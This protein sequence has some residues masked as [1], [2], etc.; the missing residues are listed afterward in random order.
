MPQVKLT[1]TTIDALPTPPKDTVYWDTGYPGF[2][3]KVTPKGRKVFVVFIGQQEPG[4]G[5]ANIPSDPMGESLS[6]RRV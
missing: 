5:C 3:I 1:K 2:G 6:T 4:P